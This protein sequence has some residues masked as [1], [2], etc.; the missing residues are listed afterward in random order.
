M[1]AIAEHSRVSKATIYK[2]WPG[3]REL[4]LEVLAR[5]HGQHLPRPQFDSGDL[6][7]DLT[8]FLSHQPPSDCKTQREKLMPS[9]MAYAARDPE[10][11]R[12]W[13][14]HIMGPAV[15]QAKAL[16]RRGIEDGDLLPDLDPNAG[17][18]FL[19]GPMLYSR[20][21]RNPAQEP[22]TE[23]AAIAAAFLRAW[24]RPKIRA[25]KNSSVMPT[26]TGARKSSSP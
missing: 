2:H 22:E 20:I 1:D 6:L 11:S 4:C 9:V 16:L 3:K 10:F 18:A 26:A 21:F 7:Q 8:G 12:A 25:V 5:L 23:P 13:R 17:V 24:G 14:L 19:I 15:Q